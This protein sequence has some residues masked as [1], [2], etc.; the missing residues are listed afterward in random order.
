MEPLLSTA[1]SLVVVKSVLTATPIHLMIALDLPKWA[2]KLIVS[3]PCVTKV[4]I[5]TIFII[6]ILY[7]IQMNGCSSG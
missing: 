6:S 2:I 1:G 5:F 3:C 7:K 4:S